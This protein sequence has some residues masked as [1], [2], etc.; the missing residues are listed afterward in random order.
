V[1][2]PAVLH[3]VVLLV[4]RLALV[5]RLAVLHRHRHRHRHRVPLA[6]RRAV[7]LAV[8]PV[9]LPARLIKTYVRVIA[10]GFG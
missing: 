1:I 2:V 9:A 6:L 5:L 7:R 8:L 4:R 10:S 3:R